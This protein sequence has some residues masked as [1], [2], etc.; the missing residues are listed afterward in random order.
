MIEYDPI[1]NELSTNEATP[2]LLSVAVPN[3]PVA[4]EKVTVPV[5]VRPEPETE[6]VKVTGAP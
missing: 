4:A 3:C 5:A 1:V 2:V 6:A